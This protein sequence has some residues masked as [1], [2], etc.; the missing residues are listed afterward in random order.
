MLCSR[1]SETNIDFNAANTDHEQAFD[2]ARHDAAR[3]AVAVSGLMKGYIHTR[4]RSSNPDFDTEL[5]RSRTE[6][7]SQIIAQSGQGDGER[8]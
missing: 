6:E 1:M 7:M 4:Q 5:L 3:K 8:A 2:I